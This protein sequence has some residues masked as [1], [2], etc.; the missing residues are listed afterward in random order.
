METT[1]N[2][3]EAVLWFVLGTAVVIASRRQPMAM[4]RNVWLAGGVFVAFGI[5]DLIEAQT[6]AWWRPWWLFVLKAVC[7]IT[8]AHCLVR[9]RNLKRIR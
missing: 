6:G 2:Y 8:L 5:S 9:H 4:R 7:V 3:C 1:F